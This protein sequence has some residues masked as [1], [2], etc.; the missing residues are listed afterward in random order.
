MVARLASR[1]R[2]LPPVCQCSAVPAG[3]RS[4]IETTPGGRFQRPQRRLGL[5]GQSGLERN[6]EFEL[7]D[8]LGCSGQVGQQQS[9]FQVKAGRIGYFTD[10]PA[11]D[12]LRLP[13]A[14]KVAK[15]LRKRFN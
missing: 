14:V 10:C 11:I 2:D 4:R 9:Q 3:G 5:P 13:R 7:F 8:R 15:R 6:R 1:E 12:G